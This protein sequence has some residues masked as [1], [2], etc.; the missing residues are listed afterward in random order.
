MRING[1]KIFAAIN[2]TGRAIQLYSAA[3]KFLLVIFILCIVYGGTAQGKIAENVV[4]LHIVANSDKQTD[5][6]LKLK[7][8]CH[9]Y[10]Y[11]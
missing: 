5:Q 2:N 4:R 9:S 11:A 10:S 7:V 1:K 3:S 6:E 8:R